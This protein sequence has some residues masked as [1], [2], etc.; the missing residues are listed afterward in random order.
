[1]TFVGTLFSN[2]YN[3]FVSIKEKNPI[4]SLIFQDPSKYLIVKKEISIF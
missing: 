2:F 1:V 3:F 4:S